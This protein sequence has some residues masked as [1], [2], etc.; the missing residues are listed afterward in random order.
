MAL[1]DTGER[2]HERHAGPGGR[3]GIH[4]MVADVD[5]FLWEAPQAAHRQQ[6]PGGVRLVARGVLRPYDH[7]EVVAELFSGQDALDPVAELRRYDGLRQTGRPET[8]DDARHTG[9]EER[10]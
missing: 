6:Q 5:D 2:R 9:V 8:L 7:R 4:D 10:E 1:R 3:F